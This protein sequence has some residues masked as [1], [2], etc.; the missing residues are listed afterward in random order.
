MVTQERIEALKQYCQ[1]WQDALQNVTKRRDQLLSWQNEGVFI[2]EN[3]G[4]NLLPTL[5]EEADS[6]VLQ[7]Q[8]ILTKMESFRNRAINGEDV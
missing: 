1:Q 2:F 8:K 6:A 5:I 3:N 7:L 4:Q